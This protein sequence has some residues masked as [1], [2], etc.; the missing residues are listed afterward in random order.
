MC[1]EFRGYAN[2]IDKGE[3]ISLHKMEI[4]LEAP[5]DMRQYL[6]ETMPQLAD[7]PFVKNNIC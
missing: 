5:N 1:N 2:S 4:P 6:K 7:R 3:S